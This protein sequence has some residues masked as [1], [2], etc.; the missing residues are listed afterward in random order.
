MYSV[1][2]IDRIQKRSMKHDETLTFYIFQYICV[3][4]TCEILH[5]SSSLQP[6]GPEVLAFFKRCQPC[7]ASFAEIQSTMNFSCQ[8]LKYETGSMDVL[9]WVH[10]Q[11]SSGLSSSTLTCVEIENGS[12]S[13]KKTAILN[14]KAKKR[15]TEPF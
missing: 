5:T 10:F 6:L 15:F 4:V 13:V 9:F 2:S 3:E 1:Y 11:S 14:S 7:N 12:R 8:T